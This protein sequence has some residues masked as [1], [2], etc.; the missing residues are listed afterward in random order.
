MRAL[1]NVMY[2]FSSASVGVLAQYY[3]NDPVLPGDLG[4][5]RTNIDVLVVTL[6]INDEKIIFINMRTIR[7]SR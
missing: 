4:R 5:S 7:F 2:A 3:R 6:K 1:L